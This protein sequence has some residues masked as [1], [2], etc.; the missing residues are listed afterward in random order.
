[1]E[2]GLVRRRLRKNLGVRA[3]QFC[4]QAITEGIT[5]NTRRL[6]NF[7]DQNSAETVHLVGHSL[8]GV[9]ALQMLKRFPTEKVGRGGLF[10]LAPR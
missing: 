2:M 5:E 7:I 4:Y 3:V 1:M 9:L 10:G 8:G 6:S